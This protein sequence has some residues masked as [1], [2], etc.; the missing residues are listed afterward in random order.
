MFHNRFSFSPPSFFPF[1][2]V[3]RIGQAFSLVKSPCTLLFYF[4]FKLLFAL[5]V[6]IDIPLHWVGL[7]GV[8]IH[9]LYLIR[10]G[11]LSHCLECTVK[12]LWL[13]L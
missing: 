5:S 8:F 11:M 4:F 13:V 10:L 9:C 3:Y 2:R 6:D 1:L 7:A 12:A